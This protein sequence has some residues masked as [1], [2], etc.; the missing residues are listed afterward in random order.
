MPRKPQPERLTF[1]LNEFAK[2]CG[3]SSSTVHG[4]IN[5]DGLPAHGG[6]KQGRSVQIHLDEVLPYLIEMLRKKPE[7]LDNDD[8]LKGEKADKAAYENRLI[9]KELVHT[10]MMFKLLGEAV[11]KQREVYDAIPARIQR[12]VARESNVVRVGQ[13]IQEAIREAGAGLASDIRQL[14]EQCDAAAETGLVSG[15]TETPAT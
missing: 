2:R 9:R 7:Y 15:A 11:L 5:K 6:G 1:S 8:R 4:W 3:V 10:E 13:I 12:A 14:A